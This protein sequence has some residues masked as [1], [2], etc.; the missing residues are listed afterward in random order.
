MLTSEGNELAGESR[1][2]PKFVLVSVAKIKF[3]TQQW[4]KISESENSKLCIH[5]T[6]GQG[7]I[8]QTFVSV[9]SN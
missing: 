3:E 5:N 6:L 1:S 9:I 7:S 4:A 8:L 2:V